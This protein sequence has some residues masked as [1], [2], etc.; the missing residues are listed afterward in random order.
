MSCHRA[1]AITLLFLL[2]MTPHEALNSIAANQTEIVQPLLAPH[3]EFQVIDDEQ[4][5]LTSG[6]FNKIIHDRIYGRMLPL[7][8]G[9]HTEDA[10]VSELR[11][12]YS[13]Y[14]VKSALTSL[15]K[16]GYIVSGNFQMERS[17]AAFWTSLGAPP[18]MVEEKIQRAGV[19]VYDD[20]DGKLESHLRAFG[21]STVTEQPNLS[22]Y[23]NRNYLDRQNIKL[24]RR[25]MRRNESWMLVSPRGMNPLFGPV[26]RPAEYGPCWACLVN[27]LGMHRRR[28]PF[29]FQN[30]HGGD[31][32][33]EPQ[34]SHHA[35]LDAVYRIIAL[36]IVKWLVLGELALIH[37]HAAVLDVANMQS[38]YHRV[39][40]RPQCDTCGEKK[41]RNP[42]RRTVPI[43]LEPNP[44]NVLNS[45]GSRSF[46]PSETLYKYKH[47][48]SPVSGIVSK[49]SR[50]THEAHPWLHVHWSD[51]NPPGN[52]NAFGL[53]RH[54]MGL[55]SS[56]K[57]ETPDQSKVSALCGAIEDYCGTFHGD[58][59]RCAKR[60]RD[61]LAEGDEL[62]IHPN[63]VQLFSDAQLES[64]DELNKLDHPCNIVPPIFDLDAEI[65]WSPVW[66]FTQNRH[67]YLPTSLLFAMTQR[68]QDDD[69][70]FFADSSG[71]AAGSTIEEAILQGLYELVERDAFAIW[72]YNRLQKPK[73][74]L[75]SFDDEYLAS[76]T[77]F[78]RRLHRR[79]WV[80]DITSDLGIPAFV[81][82]S[83]R[84]DSEREDVIYGCGAHINPR[85]AALRAVCEM[86]QCL[87]MMPHPRQ[88][89]AEYLIDDPVCRWWWKNF[90][91]ETFEFLVPSVYYDEHHCS[92]FY[93]PQV[94]NLKEEV[95]WCQSQIEA[96][97]MELLVL[98]QTRPD[99]RMPVVRVIVPGLRHY[100]PR[101]APGRLYDIPVKMSWKNEELHEDEL[102][103]LPVIL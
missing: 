42:N 59:I 11:T 79:M 50:G 21:V 52:I 61:F 102:N 78:Y 34:E 16:R 64:D 71:C 48:I 60:Y 39:I 85:V 9:V 95:I 99:I 18:N 87:S 68:R 96:K 101:F 47:L 98:D 1:E 24:N 89:N 4:V 46:A 81:A 97:G 33:T 100:W 12:S 70:V 35:V 25:Q 15:S 43:E 49:L 37:R 80:L 82:V 86:N 65:E 75:E 10:I 3:L 55:K 92:G 63:E 38:E 54:R 88:E 22:I 53:F 8:D 29:D 17:A 31:S 26:F 44:I 28:N 93:V 6:T 2:I 23:A 36:D 58:E 94:D 14:E 66:S 27:R 83:N 91:S 45:G 20:S 69:P 90:S 19:A 73:V 74:N 32:A 77:K 84:T 72:W 57:G 76:A 67:R 40:R 51:F 5:L 103:L 13:S 7:L 62:A 41:L 30:H 56:G